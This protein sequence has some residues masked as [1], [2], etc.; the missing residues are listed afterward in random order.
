MVPAHY[1]ASLTCSSVRLY[2][3][4]MS[5]TFH[6]FASSSSISW[7]VILVPLMTGFPLHTSGFTSIYSIAI[8][9]IIWDIIKG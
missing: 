5:Y 2:S 4:V 3:F 9:K 7:T 1:I 6:P 8:K